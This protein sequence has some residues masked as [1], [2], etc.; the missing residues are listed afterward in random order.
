L[1]E[2]SLPGRNY[3]R[4]KQNKTFVEKNEENKIGDKLFKI[5]KI[6]KAIIL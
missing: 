5:I 3:R 6:A 2:I 1:F 4:G